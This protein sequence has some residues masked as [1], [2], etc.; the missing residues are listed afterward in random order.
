[1]PRPE[2]QSWR[3]PGRVRGST[4]AVVFY[5][6]ISIGVG[7]H[8]PFAATTI[9]LTS[10]I[11]GTTKSRRSPATRAVQSLFMSIAILGDILLFSDISDV[12][13]QNMSVTIGTT[14][15]LLPKCYAFKWSMHQRDLLVLM[16]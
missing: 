10:A 16:E 9:C 5:T 11:V 12:Q 8:S 3:G 4:S 13:T 15:C 7:T 14:G 1:M 6:N 2:G